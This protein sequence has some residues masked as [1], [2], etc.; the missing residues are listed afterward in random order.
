[1]AYRQTKAPATLATSGGRRP[2]APMEGAIVMKD[3]PSPKP[4]RKPAPIVHC[5]A[6]GG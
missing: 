2:H 1:V 6:G 4:P 3:Y 5:R